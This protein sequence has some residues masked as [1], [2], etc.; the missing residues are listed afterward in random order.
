MTINTIRERLF[1][2]PAAAAFGAIDLAHK[3]L[4]LVALFVG[5]TLLVLF[6]N[7]IPQSLEGVLVGDVI[8]PKIITDVIL[9]ITAALKKQIHL[10]IGKRFDR[11]FKIESHRIEHCLYLLEGK[12]IAGFSQVPNGPFL[13]RLFFIG[14]H[15]I[16]VYIIRIAKPI[17][18]LTGTIG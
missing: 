7:H 16:A 15:Q 9:C 13:D 5:V 4:G 3:C 8:I 10:L 12:N 17:T 6:I 18:M 14:D 2:K 11:R 1:V